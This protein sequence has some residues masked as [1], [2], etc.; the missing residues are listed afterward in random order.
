MAPQT[1]DSEPPSP[2]SR[3]TSGIRPFPTRSPSLC[4][5][6][7]NTVSE[8]TIA[9]ATT[10]IVPRPIDSKVGSPERSMPATATSTV[11]PEMSTA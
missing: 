5:S 8:P 4:I 7:G 10:T 6:A 2:G 1:R 11:A 3:E 9:Q